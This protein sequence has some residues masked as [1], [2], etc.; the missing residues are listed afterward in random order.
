MCEGLGRKNSGHCLA[1]GSLSVYIDFSD[2]LAVL[3]G[4][5][6]PVPKSL[7]GQLFSQ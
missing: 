4:D 1:K 7:K 3:G 6:R 2:C 5:S